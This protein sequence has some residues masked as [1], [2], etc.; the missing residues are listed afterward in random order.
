MVVP[1]MQSISGDK[2]GTYTSYIRGSGPEFSSIFFSGGRPNFSKLSE[3]QKNR[4]T[5]N[6]TRL[7]F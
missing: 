1:P 7:F 6:N 5:V 3:E 2:D 4:Q